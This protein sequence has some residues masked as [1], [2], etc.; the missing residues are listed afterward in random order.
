MNELASLEDIREV[1]GEPNPLVS[2]KIYT[3]LNSRM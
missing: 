1:I 2:K 3:K